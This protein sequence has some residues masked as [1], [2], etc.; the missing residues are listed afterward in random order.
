MLGDVDLD[1]VLARDILQQRLE[2]NLLLV[3]AAHRAAR[4]LPDD[5]TTGTPR[6]YR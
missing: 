6:H 2:V 5:A 4:G 1:Q 3:A